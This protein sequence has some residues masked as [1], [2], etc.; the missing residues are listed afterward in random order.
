MTTYSM[1]P[2][3]GRSFFRTYILVPILLVLFGMALGLVVAH[4]IYRAK[5][6]DELPPETRVEYVDRQPLP[7]EMLFGRPAVP[8]A[9]RVF[10]RQTDLAEECVQL[11]PEIRR[12]VV[13]ETETDTVF[14][15]RHRF[16]AFPL[17]GGVE[18]TRN[19]FV[20]RHFDINE[21]R[22]V[23][24][25]YPRD[26]PSATYLRGGIVAMPDDQLAFAGPLLRRG[27]WIYGAA[28]VR[29]LQSGKWGV[30]VDVGFRL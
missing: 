3:S 1:T 21:S 10:Q 6:K 9:Q 5:M 2:L 28:P 12:E 17:E 25:Y 23:F 16:H 29:D 20:V 19:H 11:P 24:N 14:V 4:Q 15:P 18:T 30:M 7:R 13:R 22:W 26:R 27:R 8:T